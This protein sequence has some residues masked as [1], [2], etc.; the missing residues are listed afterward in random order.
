VT[1]RGERLERELGERPYRKGGGFNDRPRPLPHKKGGFCG[2]SLWEGL[3][4]H[5]T[6]TASVKIEEGGALPPPLFRQRGPRKKVREP[7]IPGS[8]V[9]CKPFQEG[10]ETSVLASFD[11]EPSSRASSREKLWGEE[12]GGAP[13]VGENGEGLA[14]K[15]CD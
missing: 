3:W 14:I 4:P 6:L 1:S 2:F 8:E 13:P 10:P 12:G 11:K 9:P 15:G 7:T 5:H